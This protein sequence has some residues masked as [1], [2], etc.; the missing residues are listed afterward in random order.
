M[1]GSMSVRSNEEGK[2]VRAYER[3]YGREYGRK[4]RTPTAP[5][6]EDTDAE[7]CRRLCC[8]AALVAFARLH[9]R[10]VS[11][12]AIRATECVLN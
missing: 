3:E 7:A 8:A 9:L 5:V 2:R 11:Q 6:G 1:F 10:V 12:L 4:Y